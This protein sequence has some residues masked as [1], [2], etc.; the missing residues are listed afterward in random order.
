M[1]FGLGELAKQTEL[2][3][4]VP[5]FHALLE[6][7]Q[8]DTFLDFCHVFVLGNPFIGEILRGLWSFNYSIRLLTATAITL[9]GDSL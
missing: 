1:L 3:V 5:R 8:W 6:L 9:T 4:Q 7:M 2:R